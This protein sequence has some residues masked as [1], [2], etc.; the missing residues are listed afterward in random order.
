MCMFKYLSSI[1]LVD[2][3]VFALLRKNIMVIEAVTCPR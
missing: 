2:T 3:L 1:K